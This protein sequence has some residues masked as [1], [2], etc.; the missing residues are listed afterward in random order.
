MP[1]HRPGEPIA[2]DVPPEQQADADLDGHEDEIAG[3]SDQP[4]EVISAT[5][6]VM[7]PDADSDRLVSTDGLAAGADRSKSP[8]LEIQE[9][10]SLEDDARGG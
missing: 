3:A 6:H 8:P 10:E 7:P 1:T 5:S 4:N 9:I 2:P